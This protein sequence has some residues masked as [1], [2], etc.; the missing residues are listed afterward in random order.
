M[1]WA[2][3]VLLWC[4]KGSWK[5]SLDKMIFQLTPEASEPGGYLGGKPLRQQEEQETGQEASVVD[6]VGEEETAKEAGRTRAFALREMERFDQRS[7]RHLP[8]RTAATL[9]RTEV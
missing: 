6:G 9:T 4:F 8:Q 1:G 5:G 2:G 7:D 3:E